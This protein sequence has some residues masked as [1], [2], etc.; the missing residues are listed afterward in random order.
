MAYGTALAS[1]N[2][3]RFGTE[4]LTSLGSDA[5]RHRVQELW[6]CSHFDLD[7]FEFIEEVGRFAASNSPSS[8]DGR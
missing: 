3:E 7:V 2:V 6:H 4:G 1:F 8:V 5:V